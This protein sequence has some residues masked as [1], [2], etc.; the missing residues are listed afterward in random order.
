MAV[1]YTDSMSTH[2][3]PKAIE[4]AQAAALREAHRDEMV[5]GARNAANAIA[6]E[7]AKRDRYLREAVDAGASLRQLAAVTGISAEWVRVIVRDR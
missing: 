2:L 7:T 3:T 4:A 1:N 6:R 5:R